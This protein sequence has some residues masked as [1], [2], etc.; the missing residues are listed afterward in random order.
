MKQIH[1]G[2]VPFSIYLQEIKCYTPEIL[3]WLQTLGSLDWLVSLLADTSVTTECANESNGIE[4]DDGGRGDFTSTHNFR[5]SCANLNPPNTADD[6]L[7][8]DQ[9]TET[10]QLPFSYL[11][12]T[13]H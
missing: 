4:G 11:H 12:T 7:R 8:A 1:I 2:R 9:L 13:N 10:H 3:L 5:G 6:M